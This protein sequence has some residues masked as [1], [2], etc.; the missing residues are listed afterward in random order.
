MAGSVELNTNTSLDDMAAS[1]PENMLPPE[2]SAEDAKVKRYELALKCVKALGDINDKLGMVERALGGCL[3]DS[4]KEQPLG[5]AVDLV[6][7]LK[8]IID[9]IGGDG[10]SVAL[11]KKRL[12]Y[13]KEVTM[14]ERLDAEKVKTFNTE[15]YR[16]T[17]TSKIYASMNPE[18]GVIPDG[19][20]THNPETG[21]ELNAPKYAEWAGQPMGYAWLADNGLESLVKPTVNAS[22]LSAAAKEQIENGMELPEELFRVHPKIDIS[23]TKK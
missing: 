22:S 5:D 9:N 8:K 13:V 2:D 19:G 23:I 21:E 20:I 10:G 6:S 7:D 17:K 11:V 16:V 18:G 1:V 15:R 14:P 3:V 4:L 12:A